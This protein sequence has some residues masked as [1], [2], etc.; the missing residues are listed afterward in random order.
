MH[1]KI[2]VA[3]YRAVDLWLFVLREDTLYL[4]PENQS[5]NWRWKFVVKMV[6]SSNIFK[7]AGIIFRHEE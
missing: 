6:Y 4:L 5:L 2:K 7:I 1:A 3:G